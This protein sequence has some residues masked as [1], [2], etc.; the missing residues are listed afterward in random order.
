M[1]EDW[2]GNL[3]SADGR[4]LDATSFSQFPSSTIDLNQAPALAQAIAQI[5]KAT[6]L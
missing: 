4:E 3:A 1:N 6:Q 5:V 2:G